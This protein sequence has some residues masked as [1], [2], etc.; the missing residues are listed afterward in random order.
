MC[1]MSASVVVPARHITGNR[2]SRKIF[3]AC[4]QARIDD[5]NFDACTGRCTRIKN[6]ITICIP[7]ITGLNQPN[8]IWH[9]LRRRIADRIFFNG[10]HIRIVSQAVQ[11]LLR[12]GDHK[13]IQILKAIMERST[14]GVERL[15]Y[16][17]ASPRTEFHP[18]SHF[19]CIA[20]V[21]RLGDRNNENQC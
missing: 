17:R 18:D 7:D 19:A 3:V 8:A 9:F 12:N 15:F 5:T 20:G 11:G 14:Q 6:V 4:P 13:A 2:Y 21:R 10:D 1:T 16:P